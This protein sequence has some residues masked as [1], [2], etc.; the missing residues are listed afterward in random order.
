[1]IR[2]YQPQDFDTLIDLLKDLNP[3]LAVPL[4]RERYQMTLTQ[5]NYQAFVY[6]KDGKV[7]AMMGLWMM[8]RVY[9]GKQFEIDHFIMKSECRGSGIG[10]EMLAFVENKAKKEDIIAIE[11][12]AYVQSNLAH[13]FYFK[14]GFKILG[15]HFH[16]ML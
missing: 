16:K 12:N 14:H 1:M 11:L 2:A 10:S 7:I 13:Q 5:D 8:H 6:E 15:F 9:C 4:I 3:T